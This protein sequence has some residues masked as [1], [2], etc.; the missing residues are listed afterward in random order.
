M[1]LSPN[2]DRDPIHTRAIECK[3]Y[4]RSDGLWDIE[5]HLTDVKAYPFLNDFRGEVKAG[6]PLHDM[7]IR[8]TVDSEFIV[9]K[10]EAV[11]EAGPYALCPEI[12]P[13]FQKLKGLKIGPGWNRRVR[14][15]LGGA[16]G[17]T[18]LVDML[19]PM[20]TVAFHTVRWSDSA[21]SNS[22][23]EPEKLAR[24][25]VNTCHVWASGGEK[26]KN[27]YP[28]FYTGDTTG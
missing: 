16:R 20:A 23:R 24:P 5:G 4:R 22:D 13:S 21:P 27:E 18:H 10:V 9:Q 25:P 14:E 28:D 26:I 1:P 12:L 11:T 7:W 15:N 8:L 19:K 3:S 17:C 2:V 6:E